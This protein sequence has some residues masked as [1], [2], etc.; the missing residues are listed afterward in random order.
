MPYDKKNN[1]KRK[2]CQAVL[3]KIAERKGLHP[4]LIADI[5]PDK[6]P[7]SW[8]RRKLK[9]RSV[10]KRPTQLTLDGDI[11][12]NDDTKLGL[13]SKT[14]QRPLVFHKIFADITQSA[15]VGLFL[16]VYWD[17]FNRN[18]W[19]NDGWFYMTM[20]DWVRETGMS[21]REIEVARKRLIELG[22]SQEVK[23]GVP[24]K[25][26]FRL[27]PECI[28]LLIDE[29]TILYDLLHTGDSSQD[30]IINN[31][32]KDNTE[33]QDQNIESGDFDTNISGPDNTSQ[34]QLNAVQNIYSKDLESV[35][36]ESADA[37]PEQWED[38]DIEG[39]DDWSVVGSPV[40]D[41]LE[42]K[43]ESTKHHLTLVG[44]SASVEDLPAPTLFKTGKRKLKAKANRGPVN[45]V[46]PGVKQ[47][48]YA[49]CFGADDA[50]KIGS[51]DKKQIIRV[52]LCL[53]KLE[54]AGA[55]LQLVR[56]FETWWKSTWMGWN[57]DTRMYQFPRPEQIVEYWWQFVQATSVDYKKDVA[58]N[59]PTENVANNVDI[60]KM[61]SAKLEDKGKAV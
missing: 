11:Q 30:N 28:A 41:F 48:A 4:L 31:I 3:R 26:Q 5:V 20:N 43:D 19:R 25:V 51:L 10:E 23:D 21:R 12:M 15:I 6:R 56:A 2:F 47:M 22:V 39:Q 52:S 53:G 1:T 34:T 27:V 18:H 24:T 45:S 38:F 54:K 60:N 57:K 61:M 58:E 40:A 50:R 59:R 9:Q 16:S 37:G 13:L 33:N 55:N 17:L 32:I 7:F 36:H 49:V 42:M 14:L 35:T 8:P 46:P 44:P 29:Y